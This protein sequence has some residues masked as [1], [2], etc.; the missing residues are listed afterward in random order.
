MLAERHFTEADERIR[1]TDMPERVQLLH[2]NRPA[3]F[4]NELEQEALWIAENDAIA[5][6]A[7]REQVRAAALHVLKFLRKDFFEVPFIFAH[8]QDYFTDEEATELAPPLFSRKDLWTISEQDV[9]WRQILERKR[10]M[11]EIYND[12]PDTVR[13]LVFLGAFRVFFGLFRAFLGVFP[14]FSCLSNIFLVSGRQGVC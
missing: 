12:L 10:R 1:T 14:G 11:L 4:P 5:P 9:K 13:H 6:N 8:R 7:D 3:V 2:P